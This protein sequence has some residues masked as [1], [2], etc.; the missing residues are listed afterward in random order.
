MRGERERAGEKTG[1]KPAV[2]DAGSK[3]IAGNFAF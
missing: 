3:A 1:I 2:A